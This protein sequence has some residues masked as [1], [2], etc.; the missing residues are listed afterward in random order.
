MQGAASPFAVDAVQRLHEP[1]TCFRFFAAQLQA[2]LFDVGALQVHQHDAG[3]GIFMARPI[4][5]PDDCAGQFG[6]V[7]AVAAE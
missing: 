3:L 7:R 2:Q 6:Q 4:D 5:V 1:G